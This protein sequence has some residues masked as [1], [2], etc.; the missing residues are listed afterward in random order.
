[1]SASMEQNPAALLMPRLLVVDD[2]RQ[3][4]A[5]LRLRLGENYDIVFCFGG[6]EALEAVNQQRFDLCIVDIHMPQMDGLAFIE[7]A[8]Q[9]DPDLGYVIL[10]AFDSDEN[11]RRTIPLQVCEFIPKPLPER[12]EFEDRIPTWIDHTRQRRRERIL[13]RQA[14]TLAND[15]GSAQLERDVEVIA[16]ESARDALLQTAGLLTT[17]HAHLA[18]ATSAIAARGR[19]DPSTGHL[20]RSLEEARKTAE[21]SISIT[22]TFFNSAYGSRDSSPALVNAGLLHAI[23]IASR[24]TQAEQSNKTIDF[25][26]AEDCLPIRNLSGIDFLLLVIPAVAVS[27]AL[28]PA[29]T[30]VRIERQIRARL[31]LVSRNGLLKNFLWVNRKWAI[32]SSPGV[33]ITFV[34]RAAPFTRSQ[35]E[36]WVSGESAAQDLTPARGLISGIQKCKGMLGLA[37][38]PAA[39]EFELVLALPN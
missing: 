35:A 9:V 12:I 2:E 11:L 27:L 10:S 19:H 29:N 26:P 5:S 24:M 31:D 39:E 14:G 32:T 13:V 20:L 8:K 25:E 28:A 15:L 23:S 6:S 38:A 36:A 7:R 1:M 18:T 16:S 17:I 21:A 22:E 34:A 30:T 4:H 37:V 3:I 33:Q